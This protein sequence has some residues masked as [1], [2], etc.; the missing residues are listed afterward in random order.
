V[1]TPTPGGPVDAAVALQQVR[2]V[3]RP[4]WFTPMAPGWLPPAAQVTQALGI[5]FTADGRV[6]MV[7]WNDADW[8]L[9]GGTVEPGETIE[10]AL[11][12]EVAEEACATV[13]ACR[14]LACQYVADPRNPTGQ[15]ATTRPAGGRGSPCSRCS[16]GTR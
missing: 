11:A 5:C 15:P 12:R 14:Y 2:E 13:H 6:L 16:P 7:T 3:A 9:P 10:V 1:T 4:A 8:T